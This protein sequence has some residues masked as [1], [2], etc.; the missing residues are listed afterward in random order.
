M[1]GHA[2]FPGDLFVVPV[3]SQSANMDFVLAVD[4][5][6]ANLN[7]PSGVKSQICTVED[8]LVRKIVG[9]L[10]AADTSILDTHLRQWLQI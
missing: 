7:V 1:V 10:T 8:R 3:T 4:G 9:R 2:S 6:Q 5:T